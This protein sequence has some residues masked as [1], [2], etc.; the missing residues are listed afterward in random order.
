MSVASFSEVVADALVALVQM[1]PEVADAL[2]A[3]IVRTAAQRGHAGVEYYLPCS[4]AL[5]RAQRNALIRTEFNG[6]NLRTICRKY[7]VSKTTVYRICRR[8]DASV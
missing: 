5:D 3:Q 7:D 6:A 2:A 8:D 1:S 4:N